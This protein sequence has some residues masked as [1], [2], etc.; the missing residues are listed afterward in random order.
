MDLAAALE[1]A[2]LAVL[3]SALVH[4]TGDVALLDRWD[5]DA[6]FRLRNPTAMEDLTAAEIRAF[7]AGVLGDG[8]PVRTPSVEELHRIAEFCAGEPVDPDY[9]PLI[10]AEC[11]FAG[12]DPRQPAWEGPPPVDALADFHVAIVGAGLAGVAMAVRLGRLGIRYTIFDKN[13]AVG[14]TW[15]ENDYPGLRVDVPN[16]FYSYSFAPNTEWSQHYSP[17]DEIQSYVARCAD[18][19]GVT[20]HVRFGHEVTSAEYDPDGARWTVRVQPGDGEA[21]TVTANAVVSGVGML[22]RPYVPDLPGL[23]DFAGRSFHS[24]HWPD[25]LDVTGRRV[26]VVGTGASAVQVVPGIAGRVAHLD[27][28][29]RSRHW[30]MPNPV[31]LAAMT[32]GER[33]LIANVPYYAGWLRFLLFWNNSDRI[34]DSFRIDPDWESPEV[35]ISAPNEKLRRLMTG[36]LRRALEDDEDLIDRVLPDYPP[37]GKRILQDGGWFATLRRD[38]VDLVVD[39]IERITPE[40]VVT[41]D[42][43]LHPADV[44]VLATGFHARRFLWPIDI[45]GLD[46]CRLQA[47]WG[48]EPTAYLGITVPG[49]PNLFCLYGPNTN[50]VVGSVIFML[51]C[52]VDYVVRCLMLLLEGHA[53]MDVRRDVH[54]EYNARVDAEMEQMVWRHPKVHSYCNN[55][56]GRVVTNAPWRLLD[57]WRMT[58]RPDPDD[59]VLVPV[60][61]ATGKG[62][63]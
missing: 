34:Y 44:L 27:V 51:E 18:E 48:D 9:V 53:A 23:S 14:G 43:T 24:S 57:Y 3:L 33:W 47:V 36:Y 7:A 6:F 20:P 35:S 11:D 22:N 58:R 32:E 50:P 39:P 61:G 10:E 46:G 21:F 16:L 38:D 4:R 15:W 41:A 62:A 29:Q 31:Y 26:A 1:E 42:G 2:N 49:F 30:M 40:G 12:T 60:A 28:F 8:A 13:P 59:Y 56:D 52:Q 25:D 5:R 63:P 17:R 37:L 19:H 54:D 55:D 45:V